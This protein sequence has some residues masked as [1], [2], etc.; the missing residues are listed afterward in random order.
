MLLQINEAS[1]QIAYA[2]II[3]LNK[4]VSSNHFYT[5]CCGIYNMHYY[6]YNV[7]YL[8]DLV[9]PD[10]LNHIQGRIKDINKG[11]NYFYT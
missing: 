5:I 10:Y 7:K 1:L 11:I 2:D 9:T 8:Q 4:R 3:L 6:L